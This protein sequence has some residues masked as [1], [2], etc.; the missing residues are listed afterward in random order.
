MLEVTGESSTN[1]WPENDV[2]FAQGVNGICRH[3]ESIPSLMEFYFVHLNGFTLKSFINDLS[4]MSSSRIVIVSSPLLMPLAYFWL[5]ES[6]RVCAIFDTATSIKKI[7]EELLS[8]S[9]RGKLRAPQFDTARCLSIHD[10]IFLKFY[11][12]ENSM[13]LIQEKFCRSYKTLNG[14]KCALARKFGVR[15]LSQL[16]LSF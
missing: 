12:E 3:K 2:Y 15:K 11:L 1:Y 9:A 6:S 4:S 14:R 10:V 7:K 13:S 8:I 5:A 16:V